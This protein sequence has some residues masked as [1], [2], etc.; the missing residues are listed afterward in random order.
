MTTLRAT[1]ELDDK[2]YHLKAK[3]LPELKRLVET[4]W[5]EVNHTEWKR[6]S[7]GE[8]IQKTAF[9]NWF[10]TRVPS[11]EAPCEEC[12]NCKFG[13]YE[14]GDVKCIEETPK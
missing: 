8:T 12:Y 13:R 9:G 11:V 4:C 3:R 1:M 10:I 2:S 5:T 14:D 6:L 7:D